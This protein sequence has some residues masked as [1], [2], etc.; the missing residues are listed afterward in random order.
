MMYSRSASALLSR[1]FDRDREKVIQRAKSEGV[2]AIICWFSDVEKLDSLLDQC[3]SNPGLC[4][5]LAGVHPDNVERTNKKN[6]DGWIAKVEEVARYPFTV[7][8]LSGLEK[9]A[10]ISL[11]NLSCAPLAQ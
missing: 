10:L 7:G 3:K 5:L 8:I 6:H 4:Y 1:Q 9:L 11:K 2:C